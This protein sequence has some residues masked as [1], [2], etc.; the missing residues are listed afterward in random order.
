MI[1]GAI[2]SSNRADG[3]LK[4]DVSIDVNEIAGGVSVTKMRKFL[5]A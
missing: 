4:A 1:V 2:L 5:V 3:C